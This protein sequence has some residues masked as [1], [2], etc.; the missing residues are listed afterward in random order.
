MAVKQGRGRL[1]KLSDLPIVDPRSKMGLWRCSIRI[2]FYDRA[3]FV[4]TFTKPALF[5]TQLIITIHY[6]WP[7]CDLRAPYFSNSVSTYLTCFLAP[8]SSVTMASTYCS[9]D[10]QGKAVQP[11]PGQRARQPPVSRAQPPACVAQYDGSRPGAQPVNVRSSTP[12]SNLVC[13]HVQVTS[14]VAG[15]T[16]LSCDR[17]S[18]RVTVPLRTPGSIAMATWL[19]SALS[20]GA[21]CRHQP[22]S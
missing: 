13:M 8:L 5:I 12:W 17:P 20:R 4:I 22:L 16:L 18:P 3:R 10:K 1:Y 9:Q 6:P 15:V 2:F 21:P 7:R 11:S 14:H 19:R